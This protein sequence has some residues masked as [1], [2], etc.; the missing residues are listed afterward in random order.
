MWTDR[1]VKGFKPRTKSYFV[2]ENTRRRGDGRI[3]LEVL[4][5]DQKYF[6][7]QYFREGK[8]KYLSI[9][10]YKQSAK[11][12]GLTLSDARDKALEYSA[13]LRQGVDV[14][15]YLE[16]QEYKEQERIRQIKADKYQGTF[17]QLLDSYLSDFERR[18]KRSIGNVRHALSLYVRKPFPELLAKKSTE[19]T[20]SQI[21]LIIRRM[22]DKGITTQSNR[23]RSMLHAAFQHGIK[24][25]N[26][27][28]RYA[29]DGVMFNLQF[30][31]VSAI[32]KQADFERVGDHVIPEVEIRT[33]WEVLS[34]K[35]VCVSSVLKLALMTGQ[36]PG[37]LI[38]LRWENFDLEER[39]MLIPSSVSKNGVDHLVPLDSIA[40]S[41][42]EELYEAT[43]GFECAFPGI[44]SGYYLNNTHINTTTVA[45][46]ARE[47]CRSNEDIAKFVPRDIRRTVK[48]LMGKAGIAKELRD[49]I[50]NHALQ[51]VSSKHY[52]RYDYLKEKRQGLKVW[53][54][55]MD[56]VLNPRKNVTR[57]RQ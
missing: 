29:E 33:V 35:E 27:P 24:Q 18:G 38:R 53:N 7:F 19:I 32:P 50:Q 9:G 57:L 15:T 4:P 45:K 11:E 30:N 47:L 26:D 17:E 36:R 16:E 10:R 5:G 12:P 44:Q 21:S 14:K 39:T 20:T 1:Q 37:E 25:D 54:D 23:V 51:D 46:V 56:L 22:L 48:T 43:G 55:F 28:R 41:V 52:D 42:V 8:R 31:P 34:D 49:R 2:T 6:Y 13:I 3:A 40:M